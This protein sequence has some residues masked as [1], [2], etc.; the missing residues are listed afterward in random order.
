MGRAVDDA[1]GEAFDKFAKLVGLGY[2]GGPRV[3]KE[4]RGGDVSAFQFPRALMQEGNLNFSFSGLKTA[5]ARQL[6]KMSEQE[7]SSQRKNLCASFQ[8]A[9][10][11]A[12]IEKL[13][14]AVKEKKIK[15]AVLTGGVSA[16]S[17]LREKATV[18]ANQNQ[19]QLL[20][21][22]LKYCTDNAAMIGLAGILRLKSGEISNQGL[23]PS[24]SSTAESGIQCLN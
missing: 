2:P 7:I 24:P 23:S 12:L 13:A 17:R 8:E 15:R 10:V 4:A 9:I 1:A 21:P 16:N 5:A 11:D 18:W 3:D 20:I 14:R 6:E 19:V 22:P